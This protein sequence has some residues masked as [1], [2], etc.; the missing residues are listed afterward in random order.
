MM[1]WVHAGTGEFPSALELSGL[2]AVGAP[3]R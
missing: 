3:E 2:G 1:T